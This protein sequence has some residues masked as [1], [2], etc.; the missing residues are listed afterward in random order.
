MS[1]LDWLGLKVGDMYMDSVDEVFCE[2]IVVSEVE[3]HLLSG[4]PDMPVPE[5]MRGT[6]TLI[7]VDWQKHDGTTGHLLFTLDQATD[8]AG[9][10]LEMA[11]S[12]LY[13]KDWAAI[14]ERVKQNVKEM[15][16]D[17]DLPTLE[18]EIARRA[19]FPD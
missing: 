14:D 17:M 1:E 16:A 13:G 19:D 8:M 15:R 5:E 7:R 3:A 2:S 9:T 11:M 10:I 12:N 6:K 4:N 18:E